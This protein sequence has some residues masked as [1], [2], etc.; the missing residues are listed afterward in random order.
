MQE[1][2][3]RVR[4]RLSRD[5][6]DVDPELLMQGCASRYLNRLLTIWWMKGVTYL[7]FMTQQTTHLTATIHWIW[8]IC[9]MKN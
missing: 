9:R 5:L 2:L 8:M 7:I 6:V 3:V 1:A 4:N